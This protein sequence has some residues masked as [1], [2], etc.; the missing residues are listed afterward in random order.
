[1]LAGRFVLCKSETKATKA[2]GL[3]ITF[4][5]GEDLRMI[6]NGS[7][8]LAQVHVVSDPMEIKAIAEAGSSRSRRSSLWRRSPRWSPD[9][10]AKRRSSSPIRR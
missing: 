6:E 8:K 5:D 10:A 3:T 1:M 9:A 4:S 7:I 2:T